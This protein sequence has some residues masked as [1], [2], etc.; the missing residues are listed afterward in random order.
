MKQTTVKSESSQ[1]LVAAGKSSRLDAI[2]KKTG[3]QSAETELSKKI[4]PQ[5]FASGLSQQT[6]EAIQQAGNM[7]EERMNSILNGYPA[8]KKNTFFKIKYGVGTAKVKNM[9]IKDIFK[10]LEMDSQQLKYYQLIENLYLSGKVVDA[11]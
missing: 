4:K 5:I 8:G 3:L 11:K 7:L 2:R 6:K 1:L 10:L 9:L